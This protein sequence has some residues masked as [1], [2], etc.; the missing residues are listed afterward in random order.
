MANRRATLSVCSE[1]GCA[2]LTPTGK[3]PGCSRLAARTADRRRPTAH[4]RGYDAR[5]RRTRSEYLDEH[6]FCECVDCG[7]LPAGRRPAATDVDHIDGLGPKGPRGH[8]WTNLQAL[9]HGC[10]SRKTNAENNGG[11]PTRRHDY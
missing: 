11:W 3:C 7:R 5:W 8:D 6:P 10:H 1:P 4:Q 2:S 9:A